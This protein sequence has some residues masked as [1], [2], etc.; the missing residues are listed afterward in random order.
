MASKNVVPDAWDDDWETIA[1][2]QDKKSTVPT[3]GTRTTR[4]ERREQHA[5]ENRQLWDMAESSQD[6]HFLHSKGQPPLKADFK[7]AVKVLSRKPQPKILHKNDSTAGLASLTLDDEDDSEEE[8][9]RQQE[10]TLVER[11]AKTQKEREEKQR[12]YAEVR[13][14]IFGTPDAG[15]DTAGGQS[16]S[17]RGGANLVGQTNRNSSRRGRGRT[18]R[19]RDDSQNTSADQSPARP[20]SQS[21]QL[22]DPTYSPKPTSVYVQKREAIGV[23]IAS[24]PGTPAEGQPT[25]APRGPDGSG[26]GGF[27]FANRGSRNQP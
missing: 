21:K 5:K 25:R 1:D 3:D 11:Q 18:G 14:K 15:S 13:E 10:M 9:R 19:D 26:R 12:K 20:T 17:P 16:P 24:R 27:G 23:E 8:A 2:K 7:P 4:A 22:F 6:F